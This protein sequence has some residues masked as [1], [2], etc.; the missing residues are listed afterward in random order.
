[1]SMSFTERW[2]ARY[3]DRLLG[4][5]EREISDPRPK[6]TFRLFIAWVLSV[7]VLLSPLVVM[8]AGV[9]L[10]AINFPNIFSIIIGLILI[11]FGYILMPPSI[12]NHDKTYRRQDLPS[13]FDLLDEIAARLGTTPPDGLHI[14]DEFNAYM[15]QFRQARSREQDWIIGIGLPLWAGLS[16]AER[17]ALLAHE[18]AH[19]VNDDPM[20]SGMFFRAKSVLNNWHETFA[21]EDGYYDGGFTQ[22]A[23]TAVTGAFLRLLSWFS[24]FESQRAE[25]R[26]DAQASRVAGK[27]AAIKLLEAITRADLARRAIV[28]LYPYKTNQNGRIFDCM[29]AAVAEADTAT[30]QRYLAEAA[31][32]R[33]CVDGSHPPTSLR[34]AFLDTLPDTNQTDALNVTNVNFAAIDAELQPIKDALGKELM[35]EL[36]H[37]EVNR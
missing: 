7:L 32:A 37:A 28:D 31:K 24:F 21:L 17:V 1:M 13:L 16:P 27:A 14:D 36:Y 8:C 15:A 9:A 18:M 33:R 4:Q 20:R 29:G 3:A 23:G 2:Q 6:M 30:V 12:R 10:I 5:A 34:I 35:E 11:G 26:A 19:K 25:Y 22:V